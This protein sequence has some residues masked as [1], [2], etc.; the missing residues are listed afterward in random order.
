VCAE[1]GRPNERLVIRPFGKEDAEAASGILRES[2]EAVGWSAPMIR[3]LLA[4]TGVSGFIA[5]RDCRATGLIL[6]RQVLDEGEI[7]NLAVAKGN[8]RRGEGTALSRQ[9]MNSFAMR[10]VQRVF[11]EVRESN[12]G[13]IAFY[14]RLGFRRVGRRQG[15]YQQPAEAALILQHSTNNPQL[16]TE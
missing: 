9:M 6:G 1:A 12:L 14:E 5:K 7:L 11:L 13:A 2:P 15:Y 8:R 3:D 4:T 16:G 10:G